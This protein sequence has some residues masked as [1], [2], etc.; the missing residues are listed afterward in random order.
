MISE[1][2][3]YREG[4]RRARTRRDALEQLLSD[5]AADFAL[6][7]RDARRAGL[8]VSEIAKEARLSRQAVYDLLAGLD[9]TGPR[10][11]TT[12]DRDT[13]GERMTYWLKIAGTAKEPYD[14]G[15][16]AP[17]HQGWRDRYGEAQ[18]FPRRPSVT[19][20]DRLIMYAAGSH[21]HFREG[22]IYAVE[23]VVSEPEPSA[24]AR[25]PWQVRSRIVAAGPR[26]EHCPTI[27]DIDVERR[28]VR[29]QSH[30][31]LN[32]DQGQRAEALITRAAE[33]HGAL[34]V[35]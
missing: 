3:R 9:S 22:R 20:G 13:I 25:W 26:L 8:P 23:E 4:I 31:R 30:I 27:T 11:R 7:L 29:R 35:T 17:R 19:P 10:T 34:E 24:H 28:S 18:M 2:D 12:R 21:L 15:D 14:R 33:Q 5:L 32:G 16:W 1:H 6:A